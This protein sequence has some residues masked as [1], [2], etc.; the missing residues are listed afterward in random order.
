[1]HTDT[2]HCRRWDT[3]LPAVQPVSYT[4]LK[5]KLTGQIGYTT[6][7]KKEDV[8]F[9]EG[10]EDYTLTDEDASAFL[11]DEGMGVVLQNNKLWLAKAPETPVITKNLDERLQMVELDQKATLSIS[12]ETDDVKYEWYQNDKAAIEGAQ[13]IAGEKQAKLNLKTDKVGTY[14]YFVKM[15]VTKNHVSKSIV[16]NIAHIVVYEKQENKG[17]IQGRCV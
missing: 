13:I 8:W 1:M 15:T 9:G 5:G 6:S 3:G 14:Y 11:S 17:T 2:V 16:S 7:N 4:H 12:S 10:I